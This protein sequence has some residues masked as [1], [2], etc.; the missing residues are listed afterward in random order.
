MQMKSTLVSIT[1]G[2]KIS[3]AASERS[4]PRGAQ[5]G[6]GEATYRVN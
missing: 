5:F 1:F 6:P 2:W 4:L 3:F